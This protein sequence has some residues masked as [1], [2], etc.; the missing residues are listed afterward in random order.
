MSIEVLGKVTAYVTRGAGNDRELLVFQHPTAGVQVP[1]GTV[2][3]GEAFDDAALREACE[4][5]GIAR[6]TIVR[7]LGERMRVMP[8]EMRGVLET[9][10]LRAAPFSDAATTGE[11]LRNGLPVRVIEQSGGYARVSYEERD[12][13]IDPPPVTLRTEGWAP[14]SA[15]TRTEVRRFYHMTPDVETPERWTVEDEGRVLE[16]YWAPLS[17]AIGLFG[18]HGEWL[19]EFWTELVASDG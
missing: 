14:S 8:G 2:E 12:Y 18:V 17:Q 13:T 11:R 16:L 15:F 5:T 19:A 1:A 3:R 10:D 4:E 7:M 6:L 9:V